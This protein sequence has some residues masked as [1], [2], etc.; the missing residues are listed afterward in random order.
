MRWYTRLLCVVA[1]AVSSAAF[2]AATVTIN[3]NSG[4]FSPSPSIDVGQI[5]V[6]TP[7]ITTSTNAGRFEG[8]IASA[9]GISLSELYLD[10]NDFFAYCHD[11]SQTL[12][13]TTYTVV[14]G[15][16]PLVLD[17][18]GAVNASIAGGS[19]FDWLNPTSRF[20]AAAVQIGIWEALYDTGFNLTS[21]N[22]TFSSATNA[23]MLGFYNTFV[24]AMATSPSLDANH[25]MLLT[26]PR[27]QDV[28]TGRLPPRLVSEPATLALL[29]IAALGLA[30]ARRKR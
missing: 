29:G 8:T 4:P 11:L 19:D 12:Q 22:L 23:D 14:P 27:T 24:G 26:S 18:L 15:A 5:T 21:G 13:N 3:W 7:S 28:I 10:P 1:A 25:V 2:G 20:I 6:T 16:P 9:S 17:F 30:I